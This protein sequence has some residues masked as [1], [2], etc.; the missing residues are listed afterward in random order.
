MPSTV[1]ELCIRSLF[2]DS[3]ASGACI[4]RDDRARE[5]PGRR[6]PAAARRRRVQ[7]DI[8]EVLFCCQSHTYPPKLTTTGLT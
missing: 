6:S 1:F 4:C 5:P 8:G 7:L 3:K 2:L